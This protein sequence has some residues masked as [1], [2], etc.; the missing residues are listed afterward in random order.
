MAEPFTGSAPFDKNFPL[1][2]SSDLFRK[3]S[4]ALVTGGTRGIG[5]HTAE[6][7]SKKGITVLITGRD[8]AKGKEAAAKLSDTHFLN[9]EVTDEASVQEAIKFVTA[10]FGK[11]DILVNNAGRLPSSG[12]SGVA[13]ED[14]A[15]FRQVYETNVFG[16]YNV[17]KAFLPLLRQ[18]KHPRI[19]N[20]SSGLGSLTYTGDQASWISGLRYYA[21]NSSKSALNAVTVQLSNEL[22]KD[23]F[24][25]NSADPGYCATDINNNSGVRTA[26][27]GAVVAIH[28]ATLGVDGPTGFSYNDEGREAW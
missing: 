22:Q 19:V 4:V 16:A 28:L 1:P 5:F 27:Q 17:T 14:L 21:Y 20:V 18:S 8:D 15:D 2:A 13:Q 11:L 7:L 3:G 25:V 9:L 26:A 24:K 12:H 10:K 6:G 23:G